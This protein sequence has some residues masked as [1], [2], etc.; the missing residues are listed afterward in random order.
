MFFGSAFYMYIRARQG[1]GPLLFGCIIG[2]LAMGEPIPL[3]SLSN[4]TTCVRYRLYF[5]GSLS[6]SLLQSE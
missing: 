3:Y 5:R 1:P 2:C 4:T 6:V